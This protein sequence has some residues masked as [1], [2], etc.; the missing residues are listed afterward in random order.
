MLWWNRSRCCLG[1]FDF[2][3]F[4]LEL[5]EDPCLLKINHTII[6]IINALDLEYIDADAYV[7]AHVDE[8]I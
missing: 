2:K 6:F 7:D 1:S 8:S 3:E 4:V 5:F